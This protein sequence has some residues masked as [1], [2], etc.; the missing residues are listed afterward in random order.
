MRCIIDEWMRIAPNMLKPRAHHEPRPNP[1][2][3]P[4]LP[5]LHE[6]CATC[7]QVEYQSGLSSHRCYLFAIDKPSSHTQAANHLVDLVEQGHQRRLDVSAGERLF[8][9]G[10]C[11]HRVA[12]QQLEQQAGVSLP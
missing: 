4:T 9:V 3:R 7:H 11:Q 1:A 12:K 6:P 5:M 10:E 8:R 2:T